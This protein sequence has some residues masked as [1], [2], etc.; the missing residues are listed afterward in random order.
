MRICVYTQTTYQE[1]T[2]TYLL[3]T[4]TLV[5]VQILYRIT[6]IPPLFP[7]SNK[8]WQLVYKT[9]GKR[10]NKCEQNVMDLTTDWTTDNL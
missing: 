8:P 6:P 4:E 7:S 10:L 9:V 3:N 1:W 2:S 5:S